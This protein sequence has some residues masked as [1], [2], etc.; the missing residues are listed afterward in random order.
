MQPL[1]LVTGGAGFIGSHIVEGLV[2]KGERVRVI[3]NLSTG[4]L[5]NLE[6]LMDKIEFIEGDLREP[7]AAAQ[8]A[9]GADF[10]LHQAA[11][12]SVP[13]SIEDPVGSTENNLNSTLHLLMAAH[14]AK[15]KRLVY[16]SS[17]SVYGDSPT[18]PKKEDFLPAPLSP[19]AVSKLAG[20]YYC[21][22][23]HQLYGLETVSLR[24]FNVFGP[25]QDPLSPY[26]AVIPKFITRALA[27]K[28]L[29]VYGDGE[30]SRDFSFVADVVEANLLACRGRD[31]AGEQFNVG[32]GEQ[33]SLNQL[34]QALQEII[35]PDLKVEY[36]E[37]QPGDV[38]HSLAGIEKAQRLMG[39][40]PMIPLSEGLLRTVAWFKATA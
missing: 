38:R 9:K 2:K 36:T 22:V 34:V 14:D 4:K 10:V 26:A 29:V 23:F 19:Y 37:P 15:V 21:Q 28:P 12:S 8:A 3:D 30:Q 7:K 1:Y 39:F 25:R 5:E 33:T 17:S 6:L 11:V 18:L 20:E 35:D 16:A 13:R 31:I 27:K 32:S 24:Y 40:A